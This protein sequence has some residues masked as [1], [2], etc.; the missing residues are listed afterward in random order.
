MS[1][2]YVG[3][4]KVVRVPGELD[5]LLNRVADT[6]RITCM[7][8]IEHGLTSEAL[9]IARMFE[10]PEEILPDNDVFIVFA[11]NTDDVVDM[12]VVVGEWIAPDYSDEER[13]LIYR[14]AILRG[15]AK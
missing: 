3:P 1:Y 5:A 13:L 10:D 2:T 12:N 14:N 9:E 15:L 6:Y 8:L 11:E 4:I 7:Y